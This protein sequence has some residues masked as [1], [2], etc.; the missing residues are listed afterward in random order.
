[1]A[2]VVIQFGQYLPGLHQTVSTMRDLKELN[3]NEQGKRVQRLAP[4][5]DIISEFEQYLGAPLPKEYLLLLRH[6]NGGHPELDSFLPL[7][8]PGMGRWAIDHFY[9]LDKDKNST[10]NLWL[11]VEKW[12]PILGS[13]SLPFARD[14]GGNQFYL[15]LCNHPNPVGVCIHDENFRTIEIAPSFD[16]FI[17]GLEIDPDMI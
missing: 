9:C 1:M 7:D 16:V 8:E 5:D 2:V 4:N 14:G 12:R 10:E 6:A 13:F 15:D 11:V 3:I 17:D